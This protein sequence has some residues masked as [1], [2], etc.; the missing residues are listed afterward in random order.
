MRIVLFVQLAP[1][2]VLDDALISKIKTRI[3]HDATPRHVP[4]EVIAVDEIP[5]TM[6][7]KKVELAVREILHDRPVKN[8]DSLAN[9][10]ALK[11]FMDLAQSL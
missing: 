1:D 7:G 2:T 4:N 5:Y 6:N 8:V 11:Q 10:R 9:P 3:R